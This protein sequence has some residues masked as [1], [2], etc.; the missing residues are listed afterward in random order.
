MHYGGSDYGKILNWLWQIEPIIPKNGEKPDFV[1]KRKRNDPSCSRFTPLSPATTAINDNQDSADDAL[2]GPNTPAKRRRV[3]SSFGKEKTQ[4][5]EPTPRQG[6]LS[7]TSSVRSR[8][9]AHPP[10]KEAAGFIIKA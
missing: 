3:A 10:Q 5:E 8:K 9:S 1:A 2:S 4:N 7:S 6:Q